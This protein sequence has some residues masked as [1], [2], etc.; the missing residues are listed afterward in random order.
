MPNSVTYGFLNLLCAHILLTCF[1][2]SLISQPKPQQDKTTTKQSRNVS[3]NLQAQR[4]R[5]VTPP[6]RKIR[7]MNVETGA[8]KRTRR[9]MCCGKEGLVL[10]KQAGYPYFLSSVAKKQGRSS[11]KSNG[12]KSKGRE[13]T[14]FST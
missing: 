8:S 13:G 2:L 3:G 14:R 9:G 4:G 1:L 10:R 5:G 12:S 11:G 6:R 7:A